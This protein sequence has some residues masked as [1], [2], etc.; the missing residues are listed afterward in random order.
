MVRFDLVETPL[1]SAQI[2][3]AYA[4]ILIHDFDCIQWALP[5]SGTISQRMRLNT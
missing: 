2:L 1:Y 3:V 5:A 4:F